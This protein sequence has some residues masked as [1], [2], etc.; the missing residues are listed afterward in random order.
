MLQG[1]SADFYFL[2]EAYVAAC[3]ASPAN[4]TVPATSVALTLP[5]NWDGPTGKKLNL[6]ETIVYVAS[7]A[8]IGIGSITI[9]CTM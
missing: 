9:L 3:K 8:V 1:V 4:I 7:G 6:G 5:A 2:H